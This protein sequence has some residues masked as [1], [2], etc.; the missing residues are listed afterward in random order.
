MAHCNGKRGRIIQ[1]DEGKVR[2]HLGEIV[3][4]TVQETLNALLDEEADRLC[5]AGRYQRTEARRDTRA[6]YYERSLQTKSGSVR[7]KVQASD[8]AL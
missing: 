3:R 6:G 4:G 5:N 7:L 1:I 2:E 8:A